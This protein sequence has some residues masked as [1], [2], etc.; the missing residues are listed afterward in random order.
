MYLGLK[1]FRIPPE[2]LRVMP[3]ALSDDELRAVHVPVLLLI[4][5][6]EVIYDPAPALARA[7]RLLPDFRGELVPRSSH[8]MCVSQRE[9]WTPWS[10]EFLNDR[11]LNDGERIVA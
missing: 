1:Y 9:S 3:A 4:G 8:D 2:T 5:A 7:R 10:L 11:R 6:D